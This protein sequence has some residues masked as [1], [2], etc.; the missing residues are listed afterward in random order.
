MKINYT[1]SGITKT[2]GTFVLFNIINRL[3]ERGH[4][5]SVI[6]PRGHTDLLSPQV[7]QITAITP[8][9]FERWLS[10]LCARAVSGF[11]RKILKHEIYLNSYNELDIIENI[12]PECDINVATYHMTAFP[13]FRSGKGIPFYHLQQYET[14]MVEDRHLKALAEE[15]YYLPLIKIANSTWVRS[16]IN[17]RFKEDIPVINP[18]INHNI[19]R[20]RKNK[21]VNDKLVVCYGSNLINKGFRDAVE[22]MK[23]VF[24]QRKD[25]KWIVFGLES[26]I[27]QDPQAPYIFLKEIF[28]EKL[29]DLY[30]SAH[31]VI[32]PSWVESFPLPPLEAMACGSPIITTRMGTE[33]YCFHENNSL[34][35][36]SKNP[37]ALAEAILRL[38][39]DEDLNK[40]FIH[41]GLETAKQFTWEKTVDKVENLFEEVL[42]KRSYNNS[43]SSTR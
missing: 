8:K 1:F 3:V 33:D 42:T 32:N 16:Q 43:K 10:S 40:K 25:V 36:P 20:P 13:V 23:I 41:E 5:V 37:S 39:E 17:L 21:S 22:A 9:D 24:K 15:T 27:V 11:F 31:V 29:A 12:T 34:V 6:I 18:G 14:L 4:N 30:S 35:I 38:L 7:K 19:F 28:N 26:P 2:G